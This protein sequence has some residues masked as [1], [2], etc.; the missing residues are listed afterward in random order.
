MLRGIGD[1]MDVHEVDRNL[2]HAAIDRVLE[3]A[4]SPDA[5]EGSFAN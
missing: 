1:A 5:F 4:K 2:M 3:F